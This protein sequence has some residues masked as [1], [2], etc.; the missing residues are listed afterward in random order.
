MK[1]NVPLMIFLCLRYNPYMLQ[2]AGNTKGYIQQP[3]RC[4][5][6]RLLENAERPKKR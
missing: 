1:I 3:F 6:E 2:F 5:A 4:F